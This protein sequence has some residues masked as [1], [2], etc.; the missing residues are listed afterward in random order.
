MIVVALLALVVGM[1]AVTLRDGNASRLDEEAMRL[2]ALFEGA[3]ARSRASGQEVRW[4]PLPA[5]AQR[6][7]FEFTG[8]PPS[9]GLPSTWLDERTQAEVLGA[10]LLRLGPEPVIGA[11]RLRLRLADRQLVLATDG[12]APFA[13]LESGVQAATP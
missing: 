4:Q 5:T 11:Q 2:S 12:L 13:V 9:A 8:L 1:V 3:R 7:G 6:K 10:P